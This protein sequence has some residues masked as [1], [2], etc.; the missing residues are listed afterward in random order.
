MTTAIF[1]IVFLVC[2]FFTFVFF[3][4]V[5]DYDN[6]LLNALMMTGATAFAMLSVFFFLLTGDS[7]IAK[8]EDENVNETSIVIEIE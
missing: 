7:L 3:D 1:F 4:K 8:F 2:I 5:E 6:T